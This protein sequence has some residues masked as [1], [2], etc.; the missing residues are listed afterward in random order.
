MGRYTGP[1]NKLT[2][3][4]GIDLYG[5]GGEKLAHRLEQPPGAHRREQNRNRKPTKFNKQLRENKKSNAFTVC[6]KTV[7]AFL[8][9]G[10]AQTGADW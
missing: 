2:R 7:T 8:P 3:R 5:N 4:E 9:H 6:E 10:T 1:K